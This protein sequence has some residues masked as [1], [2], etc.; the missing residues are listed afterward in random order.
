MNLPNGRSSAIDAARSRSG[1]DIALIRSHVGLRGIAA[2]LVVA[3][4]LQYRP[5]HLTVEDYTSF[6]QRSYL[7]VDLFFIL[8]GFI[9]AYV[10]R[11]SDGKAMTRARIASFWW[12]RIIRIY[13][14]HLLV[15]LAMIGWSVLMSLY[16]SFTGKSAPDIWSGDS[17]TMLAAQFLLVN[18]SLPPPN[19]WNIPSWSISAE[20]VA[21]LIF[22]L[23][24]LAFAKGR[25]RATVALAIGCVAIYSSGS[26]DLT[27]DITGGIGAVLRC[28]AGFALGFILYSHRSVFASIADPVLSVGQ[29]IAVGLIMVAMMLPVSDLWVVPGFAFLVVLT[30]HD[31]GLVARVL[32]APLMV[33]LG[34]ISYAVYIVHL[35]VFNILS[36][37]WDRTIRHIVADATVERLLF[38]ATIFP[39]VIAIAALLSL[40]FENP[41][42]AYLSSKRPAPR[43][44]AGETA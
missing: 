13:P 22:P 17:L 15:L 18:A 29:L 44:L 2:L 41:V 7:M 43:S 37:F 35:L 31:C 28:L 4:H 34:N 40:K 25:W 14:L 36:F 33:W 26:F 20:M 12:R 8:S 11:V 32:G 21:Y 23:L 30:C 10:H 27:L 6:F 24:V 19:S 16:L 3:Y 5:G 39:L 42:R 1:Q 38:I 9:M